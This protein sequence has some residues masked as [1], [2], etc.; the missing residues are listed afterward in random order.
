MWWGLFAAVGALAVWVWS[1]RL[2]LLA[3]LLWCVYEFIG[4]PTVCRMMTRQG[5]SCREP[6]RG[7]LFACGREHQELKVEAI[8]R[9]VGLRPVV[10]ASSGPAVRERGAV[11]HSR[12][13][14]TRLAQADL[15][16]LATAAAGTVV[17]LI[18]SLL[19]LTA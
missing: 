11:V 19:G 5:F 2:A 15:L 4:V 3:V 9:L 14:R 1:W 10:R 12:A 6:V 16:V 8:R 7:R 13:A 17:A 18:G